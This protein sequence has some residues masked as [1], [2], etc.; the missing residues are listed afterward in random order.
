MW[1]TIKDCIPED[2]ARQVQSTYY[3]DLLMSRASRGTRVLDLGCG[4]G[5]TIDLF[6]RHDPDVDWHGLDIDSSP[7][8]N[9]RTRDDA[10]FHTYDG[11]NIPFENERF[12][13]VYSHQTFEHVRHPERLLG[14]VAR[15]LEPKGAFVGSVSSLE[16]YHSYSYWNF[17]PYGWYKILEE[18]GLRPVEFRPGIDAI[19]IIQ[20]QY[21]GNPREASAWF[22]KSPLN[23][24]I[25]RWAKK[26]RR[27]VTQANL[28]KLQ[29]A[30]HLVFY[31]IR[32]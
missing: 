30:G 19:A 12:S 9:A 2:H 4:T 22:K 11:V 8:V 20:R 25:D 28:R 27:S 1:N 10:A 13:I 32:P 3:I 31:A 21:Q 29:F 16:P 6:R 23:E 14:E 5:R 18:A 17:T 7:E 26:D 15:V 24:D